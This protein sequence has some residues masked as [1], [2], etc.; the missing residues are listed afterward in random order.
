MASP[1]ERV[2]YITRM[3]AACRPFGVRTFALIGV[4]AIVFGLYARFVGL[5]DVFCRSPDELAEMMPGIRLHALPLLNLGAALRYNFIQSMFYSQHGLGDVSF[6]YLASGLLSFLH[7]PLAEQSLYAIGALTN[8]VLVAAGVALAASVLRSPSTG[9]IF[10]VLGLVS[11][12]FIYISRTGWARLSWTPLLLVLLFVSEYRALMSRKMMWCVVFWCLGGF[13]SLTDGVV[14]LPVVMVLGLLVADGDFSK[15]CR[16][17]LADRVFLFGCGLIVAGVAVD[18]AVGL[19]A[20]HRG[21]DLTMFAYLLLRGRE[22]GVVLSRPALAA[23][24]LAVDYYLPFRGAWILVAVAFIAAARK[25]LR[26]EIVGFIAAWWLVASILVLRYAAGISAK[27]PKDVP[28][29][30]N[31]YHL[32]VPSLLLFAWLVAS[33]LEERA[34]IVR[35]PWRLPRRTSLVI[36][37]VVF[38]AGLMGARAGLVLFADHSL[39]D[40]AQPAQTT[41]LIRALTLTS[42]QLVSIARPPLSVCR[43]LKASAFYVRSHGPSVPYV[44]QLSSNVSLGHIGEFYYGLS[45]SRSSRP[46]DPN[47][48]LDFGSEQFGRPVPPEAFYRPYN[49]SHFDYYVDFVDLHEDPLRMIVVNRLVADGARVVCTIRDGGRTIGR[50]LSFRSEPPVDLD[51]PAAAASWNRTFG[52]TTTLLVQPLAGTAYHFGYNWRTPE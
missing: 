14:M 42:D 23:W 38:L 28:S 31:S 21:T 32:A 50:V 8:L 22:G 34:H 39:F 41:F 2:T 10:G 5:Q 45:Y 18:A 27:N 1:I 19:V 47:H 43:A 33:L 35:L 11:P 4:P 36:A 16:T 13:V 37:V 52:R 25:G 44:F 9:M 48:L 40:L 49:V 12:F 7:V 30:L 15:R 29:W 24:T 46:E 20:L 6:Y 17:L 26:G 3:S 51:Y